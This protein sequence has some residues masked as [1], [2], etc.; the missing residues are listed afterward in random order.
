MRITRQEGR[1]LPT[2][3]QLARVASLV[4]QPQLLP[5]LAL[6]SL[7]PQLQTLASA[8]ARIRPHL[9]QVSG[10][11]LIFCLEF[12]FVLKKGAKSLHCRHWGFWYNYRKF[13]WPATAAA[14][15]AAATTATTTTTTA[16]FQSLQTIW[17]SYHHPK[18]HFLLWQQQQHGEFKQL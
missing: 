8:S 10:S 4:Q 9:A 5:V 7:D 16:R 17:H 15:A 11:S 1:V 6:D 13:V 2:P 18:Q 3:W 14:A 12:F